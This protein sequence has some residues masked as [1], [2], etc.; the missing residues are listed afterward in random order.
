MWFEAARTGLE[1]RS[2]RLRLQPRSIIIEKDGRLPRIVSSAREFLEFVERQGLPIDPASYR[3]AD[4]Y[5]DGKQDTS[6]RASDSPFERPFGGAGGERTQ[7][8]GVF[9]RAAVAEGVRP[10][11]DAIEAR[12]AELGLEQDRLAAERRAALQAAED[13]RLLESRC[14]A[15]EAELARMGAVAAE[16]AKQRDLYQMSAAWAEE[17]LRAMQAELDGPAEERGADKKF[18]QLRRFLARELHPDLAGEDAAERHLREAIFK[19]VWAK[20]EQLQ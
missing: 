14:A 15:L 8:Q 12:L 18:N 6:R 20:I 4:E 11:M 5:G 19:R 3:A 2:F 17:R 7:A 1:R 10:G 13:N 16:T 9:G